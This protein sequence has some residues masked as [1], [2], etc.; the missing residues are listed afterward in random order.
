MNTISIRKAEITD[1]PLIHEF[2]RGL[3]IYEKLENEFVAS[4]EDLQQTLFG[5]KP[6]AEVLIGELDGEPVGFA[7]Y[8]FNY[9]TFLAK[10]GIWLEDLFVLPA[11]RGKGVGKKLLATL[12]EIC[13]E[14]K[15]GRLEWSVLDWNE[16]S[17]QFYKS[18][19]A[20]PMD[21]WTT[22]RLTGKAIE[23]LANSSK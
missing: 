13:Q 23:D 6:Y 2:I 19:G 18:L 9:S 4:R 11:H 7:L 20:V 5:N 14:N 3:A 12:A 8:F 1:V 22:F 17:I 16:P 15:F 10:P 21:E